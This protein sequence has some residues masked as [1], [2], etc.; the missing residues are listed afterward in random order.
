MH[1]IQKFI[2]EEI[3]FKKSV[4]PKTSIHDKS[5]KA[6]IKR[7]KGSKRHNVNFF[8]KFISLEVE[9]ECKSGFIQVVGIFQSPVILK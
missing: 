2:S 4:Q 9:S 7:K 3:N 8:W 5:L 1:L 6:V